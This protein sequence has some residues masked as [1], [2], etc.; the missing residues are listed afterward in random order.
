MRLTDDSDLL[1]VQQLMTIWWNLGHDKR[2]DL[3]ISVLGSSKS[4]HL[5]DV[6]KRELFNR[7]LIKVS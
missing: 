3:V 6:Q 7:G 2:P 5:L 4:R 1:I